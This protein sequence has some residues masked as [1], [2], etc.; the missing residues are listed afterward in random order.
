M[1]FPRFDSRFVL[2]PGCDDGVLIVEVEE[3]IAPPYVSNG[4]V[5]V[6][7]GSS[8]QII[9]EAD[10]YAIID[11]NRK[12]RRRLNEIDCFNCRTVHYPFDSDSDSVIRE[13]HP[14]FDVYLKRLHVERNDANHYEVV[15]TI[16]RTF[17]DIL[18]TDSLPHYCC[19]QAMQS[20][21]FK[22]AQDNWIDTV[23]SAFQVFYNES[24]KLSIPLRVYQFP[25]LRDAVTRLRRLH[26]IYHGEDLRIVD[27]LT[28]FFH[29]LSASRVVDAYLCARQRTLADYSLS[30]EFEHMQGSILEFRTETYD[31]YVEEN[32]FLY[33]STVDGHT[34]FVIELEESDGGDLYPL[35]KKGDSLLVGSLWGVNCIV[36]R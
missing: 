16:S 14:I 36:W 35:S 30:F 19:R 18:Q 34:E 29:I 17:S 33:F 24:I 2:R 4:S 20:L 5:Y 9:H 22:S 1:P 21:V 6:R 3:G 28:Y 13:Y 7:I 12:A 11:L 15:N 10:S 26:D 32:G 23:G 8:S 25:N 31:Q 27:G